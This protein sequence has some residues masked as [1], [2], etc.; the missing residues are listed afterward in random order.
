[1]YIWQSDAPLRPMRM[2]RLW[3]NYSEPRHEL[4]KWETPFVQ[5]WTRVEP[6]RLRVEA[7]REARLRH[8]GTTGNWPLNRKLRRKR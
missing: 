2:V 8:P 3:R 5:A 7:D 6:A 1:M 4:A